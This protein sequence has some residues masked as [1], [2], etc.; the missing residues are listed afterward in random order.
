[1]ENVPKKTNLTNTYIY[2]SYDWKIIVQFIQIQQ[3]KIKISVI[4][5]LPEFTRVTDKY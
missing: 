1:M 4:K 3:F 5:K 2:N